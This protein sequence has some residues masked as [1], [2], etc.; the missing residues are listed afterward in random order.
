MCTYVHCQQLVSPTISKSP[1]LHQ[2]MKKKKIFAL[3]MRSGA[4]E[5]ISLTFEPARV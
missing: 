4:R 2:K 3:T 5:L 1:G